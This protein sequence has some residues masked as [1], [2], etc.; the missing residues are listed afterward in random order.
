MD[1]NVHEY[2]NRTTIRNERFEGVPLLRRVSN[3]RSSLVYTHD[4]LER[5]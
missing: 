1:D 3:A 2:I 4:Q 5:K